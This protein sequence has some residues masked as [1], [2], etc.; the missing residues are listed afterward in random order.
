MQL[1]LDYRSDV[2]A[3]EARQRGPSRGD[4]LRRRRSVIG[5]AVVGAGVCRFQS[6]N[7]PHRNMVETN[8]TTGSFHVLEASR[9]DYVAANLDLGMENVATMGLSGRIEP[10][11]FRSVIEGGIY[12]CFTKARV[13]PSLVDAFS[14]AL[15]QFKQTEEY[16]RTYRKYYNP[17]SS[18]PSGG[19]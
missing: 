4:A 15:K 14:R 7:L 1:Y 5:F 2:Q 19:R 9:V 11:L 8:G 3:E 18:T 16:R 13:S 17:L 12:T 6:Q 10:L